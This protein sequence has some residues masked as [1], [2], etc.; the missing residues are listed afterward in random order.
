[1]ADVDG[2]VILLAVAF[3]VWSIFK[4]ARKHGIVGSLYPSQFSIAQS[5]TF[6]PTMRAN[7]LVLCVTTQSF[8][9]KAMAAI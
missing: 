3:L 6:S 9:D 8:L 2:S 7:S 4:H 5:S 1:M